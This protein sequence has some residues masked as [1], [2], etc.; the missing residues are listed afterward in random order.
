MRTVYK[1]KDAIEC[2]N[3]LTFD[4]MDGQVVVVLDTNN[5]PMWDLR[6]SFW[7]NDVKFTLCIAIPMDNEYLE[8]SVWYDNQLMATANL[9]H[10][11]YTDVISNIK[12]FNKEFVA[13][14]YSEPKYTLN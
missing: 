11:C 3:V 12:L 1:I 10:Y 7:Y 2:M 14:L 4:F 8:L 9:N 6:Q 5:Q 13:K